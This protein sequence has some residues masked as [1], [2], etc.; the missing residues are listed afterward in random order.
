MII[1]RRK[2]YFLDF[3]RDL[4]QPFLGAFRPI[5]MV[6]DISFEILY[7]VFGRFKLSRELL[8][9]V[10]RT[11][12]VFISCVSRLVKQAQNGLTGT[13]QQIGFVRNRISRSRSKL[14]DGF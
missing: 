8:S 11:F 5:L 12:A 4:I 7:P 13:V 9:N 10:Q 2:K 3:Y 14:D 1:G 6:P